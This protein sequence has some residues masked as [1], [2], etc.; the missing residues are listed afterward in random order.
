MKEWTE[1]DPDGRYFQNCSSTDKV[2]PSTQYYVLGEYDD[3]YYYADGKAISRPQLPITVAGNVIAGIPHR[4]ILTIAEQTYTVED[5]E[6]EI[7]GY[8]GP[9]LLSCWP[10]LDKEVEI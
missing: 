6:V 1:F 4:T 8:S 7:N 3:T 5:G 10:Y 9:V 2:N